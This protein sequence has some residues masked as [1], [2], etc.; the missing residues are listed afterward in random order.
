MLY[1]DGVRIETH[2][3]LCAVE[4]EPLMIGDIS[5]GARFFVRIISADAAFASWSRGFVT[6]LDVNERDTIEEV[7][8]KLQDKC[9]IPPEKLRLCHKG[10]ELSNQETFQSYGIVDDDRSDWMVFGILADVKNASSGA[11]AAAGA[12]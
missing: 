4:V 9:G 2:S 11:E 8:T 10:Q 6:C 5:G 1:K 12:A 3:G 7:K